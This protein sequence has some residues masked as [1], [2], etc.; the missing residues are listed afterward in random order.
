MS[1]SS[2][3]DGAIYVRDHTLAMLNG[4]MTETVYDHPDGPDSAEY[5][6]YQ[7]VYRLIVDKFGGMFTEFKGMT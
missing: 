1:N 2:Y 7:K 6:A 5:Q 3:F 4:L